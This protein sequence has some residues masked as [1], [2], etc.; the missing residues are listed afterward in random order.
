M[1]I[2]IAYRRKN[3]SN[4]LKKW[5]DKPISINSFIPITK[6]AE[7]GITNLAR[8][9]LP[10]LPPTVIPLSWPIYPETLI[11]VAVTLIYTFF[12]NGNEHRHHQ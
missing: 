4:A 2:Y 5:M 1:S 6:Q 7:P 8:V 9:P 12:C 3:A 10:V 11:I